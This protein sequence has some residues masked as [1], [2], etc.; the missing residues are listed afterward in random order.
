MIGNWVEKCYKG[1]RYLALP[2]D[3]PRW[4]GLLWKTL[5]TDRL[6][7]HELARLQAQRAWFE[8]AG[9]KT[10]VDVGANTG[11]FSFAM[12]LMLPECQI[13]AFEPLPDCFKALERNLGSLGRFKGF[14]SAIG[15]RSGEVSFYRSQQSASSSLLPMGDLHR[16]AF[17][18]TAELSR[19]NVPLAKLDDFLPQ[20][21][22]LKPML[23]KI[24]VQGYE[25]KVLQGADG[26][27]SQADYLLTE[28]SYRPLYEGQPLF[29]EMNDILKSR[30][31]I[32]AGSFDALISPLDGSILQSD[33]L[34]VRKA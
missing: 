11:A 23:L 30:G 14:C 26:V 19:V 29:G 32:Y 31:F 1:M 20:M 6:L 15:E 17:P 10:L 13:Y 4:F 18:W 12:R 8:K 7:A 34:F 27:L 16:Q 2:F 9:F 22:L 25:D 5:L 21:Q 3:Y 24:D 28:V 33:A